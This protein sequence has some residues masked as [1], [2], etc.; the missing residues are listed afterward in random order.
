MNKNQKNII[1]I[2]TTII[3]VA[4][5]VYG[6]IYL[7][8]PNTPVVNADGSIEGLYSTE[9][10]MTLG[11]PYRCN[12]EKEDDTSKI[13]GVV[14]TDGS[15]IKGEF[16]IIAPSLQETKE[17]SS[18]LIVK[19][20]VAYTWTSLAPLGYKGSVAKSSSVNASPAEQ[21]QIVGTRDKIEYKCKPLENLDSTIFD[22][23]TWITFTE[24]K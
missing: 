7:N 20:G 4:G 5:L 22:P 16:R 9:S 23:P 12:F 14:E 6:F 21:A 1:S 19:E 3:V 18:F 11:K 13:L 24:I 15:K 8:K 17:F 2:V 10:I